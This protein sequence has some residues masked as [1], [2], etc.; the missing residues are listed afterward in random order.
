MSS[1][2]ATLS[3]SLDGVVEDRDGRVRDLFGWY[4]GEGVTHLL[5]RVRR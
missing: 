2:I 5:Y 1:V 4:T 3:M